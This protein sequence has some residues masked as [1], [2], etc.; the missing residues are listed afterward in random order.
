[1]IRC[2]ITNGK[3]SS[4]EEKW[5]GHLAG[6]IEEGIELVQIRERQLSVRKLAE[7]TRKVLQIPNPHGTKILV[8]DR[9][10][11]AL[12]CGA[13]GVHLRDGSIDAAYFSRADFMVTVARHLIEGAE[14]VKGASFVLLA[15]VF[16]PFSKENQSGTLGTAALAEFT[17]RS[18]TPVLALGGITPERARQCIEAGAAGIAGISCFER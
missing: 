15:P 3:S 6:W 17:R 14:D 16:E 1:V 5:L 12:A 10:D 9:A 18:A 4:N 8:N 2:L 13:H 7:L 11:V